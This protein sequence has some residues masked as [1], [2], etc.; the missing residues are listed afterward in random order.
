MVVGASFLA[1]LIADGYG[2]SFGI[3]F[4][5]L[6]EV[7]G[8][9]K[10]RTA[11]V[12]SLFVSVPAICGPVASA[13][14]NRFG[15]RATTMLGGVIASA[16]C[17]MGAFATSIDQLCFTFG[18]VAG[19]GLSLVFV[20]AVIVVAF[21][22][23]KRRA[24]ATGLAVA[25]SGI[26]TFV[27]APLTNVLIEYYH[28]RGT[29]MITA[30]I[31]LNIVVCGA[32]F[33]PLDPI[34]SRNLMFNDDDDDDD[35]SKDSTSNG[36]AHWLLPAGVSS[37]T[38][39]NMQMNGGGRGRGGATDG[40][41]V[42]V[43]TSI[44]HRSFISRSHPEFLLC[45]HM[46]HSDIIDDVSSRR[47]QRPCVVQSLILLPL[48]EQSAKSRLETH[49]LLGT[50]IARRVEICDGE[51]AGPQGNGH[52][53]SVSSCAAA[54]ADRGPGFGSCDMVQFPN[55]FEIPPNLRSQSFDSHRRRRD[56]GLLHQSFSGVSGGVVG[57]RRIAERQRKS[58][59]S[60]SDRCVY[61]RR[62]DIVYRGS[63]LKAGF[64]LSNG[65]S[66]SCPN[67]FIPV[68]TPQGFSARLRGAAKNLIGK[69]V[70]VMDLS[71]CRS[72][73]FNYFCLHTV[74][75]YISYD[76]PYVYGPVRVT[77]LG[78]S[79]N[80]AS[81]VIA[82]IGIFSTIGQVVMGYVGDQIWVNV[83]YFYNTMTSIAGLLT[84][85]VPFVTTF[86][87]MAFL[88]A[89]YGFFISANFA[90]TTVILVELL[91]MQK[92]TNAFGMV[93]LAQGLANLVGPPLAGWLSD[94]TGSYDAAFYATGFTILV[95]GLMLFAAPYLAV[96][97]GS[98]P[99][100]RMTMNDLPVYMREEAVGS[101]QNRSKPPSS[102]SLCKILIDTPVQ[103][104]D[105]PAGVDCAD[106]IRGKAIDGK[107]GG[108]G[109]GRGTNEVII[110]EAGN[111]LTVAEKH[112]ETEDVQMSSFI[113][114]DSHGSISGN[115]DRSDADDD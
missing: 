99:P 23:K 72:N 37:V 43:D 65:R 40:R 106:G 64:F 58:G 24:F 7:F 20:P 92:L 85:L 14:T 66:A 77:N 67:V 27:F 6:L 104:P 81:I 70:S 79:E 46:T 19:F 35:D 11:W 96:L 100:F 91:G 25:G 17:L 10:G 76:I 41:R 82:I 30:G 29:L 63:L 13:V 9:S 32:L 88:Y 51:G 28:W 12:G 94:V 97:D 74:L 61:L 1:H 34:R 45:A 111:D 87:P 105:D 113:S 86:L 31:F 59:L 60:N 80:Y 98:S 52:R 103:K 109:G 95:S 89:G 49:S 18:I 38:Q 42:S 47:R 71:V 2:F 5:E 68:E 39:V 115:D 16:G 8:E 36:N 112:E 21:Y 90:L 108:G 22:F 93:S 57:G 56:L 15:C 84:V 53:L 83:L 3:L 73:V 4:S 48:R 26:G 50:P 110:E 54:A 33:R 107:G 101:G 102:N 114:I 69:L 62:Q 55:E 44:G 78:I 75:L